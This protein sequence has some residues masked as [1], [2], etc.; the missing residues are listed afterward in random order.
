MNDSLDAQ[1]LCDINL[2]RAQPKVIILVSVAQMPPYPELFES[3]PGSTWINAGFP[4]VLVLRFSG[5]PI[6][7]IIRP[8]I[9][10]QEMLRFPGAHPSEVGTVRVGSPIMRVYGR[11][12]SI[13]SVDNGRHSSW[14]T[15]KILRARFF[16]LLTLHRIVA[17]WEQRSFGNRRRFRPALVTQSGSEVT[18]HRMATI[19]NSMLIQ[20]DLFTYFANAMPNASIVY[21]TAS[22]YIDQQRLMN[23]ISGP[24]QNEIVAGSSPSSEVIPPDSSSNFFSG[25][26]Q[27]FSPSAVREI[28]TAKDLD[29]FG[30][31]D[32]SLTRW[33]KKRG[34]SWVDPGIIW[35]VEELD[36]GIC[37]LCASSEKLV[38]RCTSHGSREREKQYMS[39]LFH[40]HDSSHE[41]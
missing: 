16:V 12:V 40:P 7:S 6:P 10:L 32:D 4:E 23:W 21:T 11:L 17:K 20:L 30:P 35:S 3:G 41:N 8:F 22:A 14:F 5:L 27:Y 24:G 18:V 39:L 26:F 36:Q 34:I 1:S 38:V 29:L 33:L 25:F 13:G 2:V 9:D 19:S 31:H 37:P 28:S 15:R